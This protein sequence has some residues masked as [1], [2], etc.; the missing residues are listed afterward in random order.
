MGSGS[1]FLLLGTL[2]PS[3][4]VRVPIGHSQPS[5]SYSRVKW[6]Q[7]LPPPHHKQITQVTLA[8]NRFVDAH[9]KGV[10]NMAG[11]AYTAVFPASAD[12]DRAVS[13]PVW[14]SA[15]TKDMNT[16]EHRNGKCI[17]AGEHQLTQP[18]SVRSTG[19]AVEIPRRCWRRSRRY[20]YPYCLLSRTDGRTTPVVLLSGRRR[21]HHLRQQRGERGEGENL[22]T[23]RGRELVPSFR[24]WWYRME[25]PTM[26]KR[27]LMVFSSFGVD[28]TL[29]CPCLQAVADE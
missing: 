26:A 17:S 11:R 13:L 23:G 20:G 4:A 9:R 27:N 22:W 2:E 18:P 14:R 19:R 8:G 28:L 12:L 15:S 10:S 5:I 29:V 24:R 3:T 7:Q 21:A 16:A 1:L 25:P 6:R